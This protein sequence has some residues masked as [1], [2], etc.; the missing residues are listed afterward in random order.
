[1]VRAFGGFVM[2]VSKALWTLT[3]YQSTKMWA[4]KGPGYLFGGWSR[5]RKKDT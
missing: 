1:M 5:T 4:G 2:T 3:G